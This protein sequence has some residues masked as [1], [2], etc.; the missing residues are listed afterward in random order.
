MRFTWIAL[1]VLI[2]ALAS[3]GTS[4]VPSSTDPVPEPE[5]AAGYAASSSELPVAVMPAASGKTLLA[6]VGS[7]LAS[8]HDATLD[9]ERDALGERSA[10]VVCVRIRTVD[11]AGL[12]FIPELT[13]ATTGFLSSCTTACPPPASC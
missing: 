6:R 3:H 10:S 1:P 2:V 7:E 11:R 4:A 5:T 12:T 8:R 13:R 9:R